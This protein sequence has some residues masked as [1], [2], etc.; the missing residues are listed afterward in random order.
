MTLRVA[1]AGSA[2]GT[3]SVVV[4]LAVATALPAEAQRAREEAQLAPERRTLER[5]GREVLHG[6]DPYQLV[7][8]GAGD[9]EALARTPALANA[10]L[11]L[12]RVDR[13]E[14]YERKLAMYDCDA[15]FDGAPRTLG[16][17]ANVAPRESVR[18]RN[19][20]TASDAPDANDSTAPAWP[21]ALGAL[22]ALVFCL[23]RAVLGRARAS[24]PPLER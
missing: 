3:W 14:L 7:G 1:L 15:D 11:G 23:R 18:R 17:V 24:A 2:R 6:G 10:T 5:R 9:P 16:P 8:V 13:D 19:P 20:L 4:A 12:V 21:W 22:A